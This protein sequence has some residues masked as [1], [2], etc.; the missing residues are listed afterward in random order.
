MRTKMEYY[1]NTWALSPLD[2]VKKKLHGIGGIELIS[3]EKLFSTDKQ[4]LASGYSIG[5]SIVSVRTRDNS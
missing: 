2:R 4:L 1:C 3:T 5:I